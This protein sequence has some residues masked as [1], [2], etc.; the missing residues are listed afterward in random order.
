MKKKSD[1]QY[2]AQVTVVVLLVHTFL[3][4]CLRSTGRF[5]GKMFSFP[6]HSYTGTSRKRERE[7]GEGEQEQFDLRC[8]VIGGKKKKK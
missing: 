7:K 1:T 3:S 6:R 8:S 2:T 4:Y 5:G